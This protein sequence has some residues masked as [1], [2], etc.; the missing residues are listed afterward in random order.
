M[1]APSPVF[2]KLNLTAQTEIAVVNAPASFEPEIA[3]L[4]GVTVRRTLAS[5]APLAFSLAFVTKQPE[6]DALAKAVADPKSK[7]GRK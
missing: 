7:P 3:T 2:K 1:A 6:V 4:R 5:G